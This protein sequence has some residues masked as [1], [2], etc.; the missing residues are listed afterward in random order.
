VKVGINPETGKEMTRSA[1]RDTQKEALEALQELLNL[2][3]EGKLIAPNKKETLGAYLDRWLEQTVKP[4]RS[5][6]TYRAYKSVVTVH[7]KPVLGS[8]P[9]ERVT[10]EEVKAFMA[11]KAGQKV[12]MRAA[13]AEK[14][15]QGADRPTLS[16]NMLDNILK[17]LHAAYEEAIADGRARMNP[18]HKVEVPNAAPRAEKPNHLTPEQVGKLLNVVQ[19]ENHEL[20]PLLLFLFGTGTRINEACGLTWDCLDLGDSPK[21]TIKQQLKRV[22]GKG[23]QVVPGTKT[24]K[25]GKGDGRRVLHLDPLVAQV[26]RDLKS[27]PFIEGPT[28]NPDPD[29]VVFRRSYGSRLDDGYVRKELKKLCEMAGV[30]IITSHKA[31]HT[32]ITTGI[33][34]G[35]PEYTVKLYVGHGRSDVTSG[36]IHENEQAARAVASAVRNAYGITEFKIGEESAV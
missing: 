33:H 30:P 24:S 6:S 31:R 28:V 16:E 17:V 1:R 26:L 18:A 3:S 9:M 14:S 25:K 23:L 4:K 8:K 10:R 32:F 27:K 7:L 29:G 22:E 21:A 11:A 20:A 13:T 12:A 15:K 34:A 2:K 19:E 35:R 36:Y 5:A